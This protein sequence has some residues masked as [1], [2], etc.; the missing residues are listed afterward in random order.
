MRAIVRQ[1]EEIRIHRFKPLNVTPLG[2]ADCR[3]V[4]T[5][6]R[7]DQDVH[8]NPGYRDLWV[9]MWPEPRNPIMHRGAIAKRRTLRAMGNNADMFYLHYPCVGSA[10]G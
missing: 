4:A 6:P 3:I 10:V 7:R 1:N 5:F 8:G 2:S 9:M